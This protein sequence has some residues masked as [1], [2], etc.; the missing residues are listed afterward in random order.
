MSDY[1]AKITELPGG[2]KVRES[3]LLPLAT[4]KT[5][6]GITE[7]FTVAQLR[8]GLNYENA[9]NTLAEA[10]P[11]TVQGEVFFVFTGPDKTAVAEYLRGASGAGQVLDEAG[12]PVVHLTPK[13]M[14]S[15]RVIPNMATLRTTKPKNPN[16]IVEVTE[17]YTGKMNGG[18][19][20]VSAVN[21][22]VP[23]DGGYTTIRVDENTVWYR[24]DLRAL[25]L[26]DGGCDNSV[27]DN[28]PFI[29]NIQYSRSLQPIKVPS[30]Y[31]GIRTPIV[32]KAN[33]GFALY[34]D[35]AHTGRAILQWMGGDFNDDTTAVLS[36]TVD[37]P[38]DFT[39]S[40]VVLKG[41]SILGGGKV[42]HGLYM[43]NVGYPEIDSL[44]IENFKGAGLL[45]D[46]VQDGYFNFLEVQ[47]CGRTS[48]DYGVYA[49]L[50]NLSKTQFAPIH[51]ISSKSGD[52]SNMLRFQGGQ[53]EANN[54]SPTVYYR[55]GIGLWISKI[56]CEQRNGPMSKFKLYDPNFVMDTSPEK[57]GRVFIQVDGSSSSEVML[58]QMQSS[59]TERFVYAGGYGVVMIT[60]TT[61]GGGICLASANRE[62]AMTITNSWLT[63]CYFGPSSRVWIDNCR[64]GNLTWSY[65]SYTGLISNTMMK[66]VVMNND[67]SFPD[68]NF[69][70]CIFDNFTN[71]VK[72]VRVT[73]GHCKGN[74]S[75]NASGGGGAVIGTVIDGT[76]SVDTKWGIDF[77]PSGAVMNQVYSNNAPA[78]Q[79]PNGTRPN[80]SIWVNKNVVANAPDGTPISW[81]KD[82]AGK[83]VPF[84]F[85]G[86]LANGVVAKE[87][88]FANLPGASLAKRAIVTCTDTAKTPKD[89]L[90]YSDGTNWRYV[91]DPATVVTKG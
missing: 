68:I 89:Q 27:A 6:G 87:Y 9:Y 59:E 69:N 64:L 67:G 16:E 37:N 80:G 54:C 53:W 65:P 57:A 10:I 4:A 1:S 41:F 42:L 66:D 11:D 56:H 50:V 2:S 86:T 24:Q 84:A 35:G 5:A 15:Y 70:N 32:I 85:V 79:A 39:Y 81:V 40:G 46:Q 19:R 38:T 8:K 20:F 76:L 36:I 17:Y 49:D 43:R 23:D 25:T 33:K 63:D 78:E 12:T 77:R 75:F 26:W 83:W 71:Y 52:A 29:Q 51:I 58:D 45:L 44:K 88:T 47:I 7:K 61:R 82:A 18:G 13:G 62:F 34:A 48:G 21:T 3:S 74:F 30:Q 91:S 28:G 14:A 72:N 31:F 60:N 90:I 55:G 73:G 22:T